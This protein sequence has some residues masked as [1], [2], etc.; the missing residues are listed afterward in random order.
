MSDGDTWTPV[1][2]NDF[3]SFS[4]NDGFNLNDMTGFDDLLSNCEN[5]LLSNGSLF[6]DEHLLSELDDSSLPMES[7][8][9]EFN[10]LNSNSVENKIDP[11]FH[12]VPNVKSNVTVLPAPVQQPVLCQTQ[13]DIARPIQQNPERIVPAPAAK[14]QT[15]IFGQHYTIAPNVN[16]NVPSPIVTLAPVTTQQR[17]LLLPAKLIKSEPIV[18]SGRQQTINTT[19][20]QHQIHTLVNTGN[21]TVLATGIPLVLDT[22]KV[23]INRINTSSHVTVPKVKE[24]K[25]SAHNAIERRYRTSINDKIIELKNIVVGVDAKLNKSAI[26]RKTIDYIRFLQNSNAKLKAENMSLKMTAQRQNLRELL[27]CGELTPPRSD[28]SEPSLSPA[29]APMSPQSPPPPVIKEEPEVMQNLRKP[30][31]TSQGNGMPDHTRVSLCAFLFIF[32]A[33]N[34]LGF[35]MNNMVR[36]NYD[37]SRKLE[38][39]TILNFQDHADTETNVWSNM[40][41]WFTNTLLLVFGMCR[42]LLYAD[43]VLPADSKVSVELHRWRR[44]AEFNISRNDYE[45]GHRDL[46]QCLQYFSRSLPLTRMDTF[47]VTIWQLFRQI[48]H[49]LYISRLVTFIG[50]KFFDKSERS[51]AE[52]SAMEIST[53]YQHMLCLKLSQDSKDSIMH[54]ALSTLNYAEAAGDTMPKSMLAEIYIN[55][56]LCF[57]QSLFPFVHKFY[58][59]KARSILASCIVPQKLKWIM[60][61]DGMK[62]LVSQKWSYGQKEESD[63]TVQNNKSDPL[64]YAARAYREHLI[65]Q[66]LRLLAGTVSDTHASGL[67]DISKKIMVSAQI[68][69]CICSEEKIGVTKVEDEVGLWWGAVMCVAANFRLGEED[70]NA[71]NIV[72]GKFPF[73]KNSQ[74]NNGN[75]LPHAVLLL[76]QSAR[77]TSK[78]TTMR[79]V[80]QAST[81]LE[82]STVY[83]NCKQQSSQNVLL[84]ELWVCDWLLEMR[85]TLWEELNA[86]IER[87]TINSALVGFQ[88][89]LACM[90]QLCQHIPSVLP[91]VFLYE[92][93][94]RIMAGATPVKTQILLDRSLHHRNSRS[95]IICG[96][97]RSHDQGSGEREHAAALCL[98]CRHLPVLL[99][100]SPGERAGMLAEAAKTLE[101]LGDKKRLQECYELIKQLTPAISN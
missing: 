62:F 28:T 61:D 70:S 25:R 26:L 2:D 49:R 96:K 59:N 91:R 67:L 100:A 13:M 86:D 10:F 47:F 56:A 15:T 38:G 54:I 69:L 41:I 22:E 83:N 20:V 24:V 90:R 1:Q 4:A 42:L 88:R 50:K 71:W 31:T 6:S 51:L 32:L 18:Y 14:P 27:V 73:E 45:Q 9:L 80:D 95:S 78:H 33:F 11:L 92:A 7:G 85:T 19:P 75:P 46:S 76:L 37:Y 63:F 99:L 74:L 94:A 89:D 84:T 30:T 35:V 79:L 43:P 34:P 93:T 101:R 77:C 53:V 3:S 60:N 23:Q 36:F 72:E 39:R 12:E 81:F 97:D 87:P 5:E 16:F 21:G 29:P 8:N 40:I 17:Q 55:V 65:N 44:Q 82:H 58:L 57:K 52:I 66:G 48:L 68:D 98:A 64:S